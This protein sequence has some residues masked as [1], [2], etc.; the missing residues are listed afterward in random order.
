M[1]RLG[2]VPEQGGPS[3][4]MENAK[5]AR[6]AP[7]GRQEQTDDLGKNGPE[8]TAVK[9]MTVPAGIRLCGAGQRARTI[10]ESRLSECWN[11]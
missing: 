11:S 1:V 3:A 2:C 9:A 6:T 7:P 10:G 8:T 4:Y 5:A